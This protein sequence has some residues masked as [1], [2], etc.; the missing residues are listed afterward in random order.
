MLVNIPAGVLA[1]RPRSARR[2]LFAELAVTLS[3]TDVA[4]EIQKL[5]DQARLVGARADAGCARR[6]LAAAGELPAHA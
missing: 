2:V 5:K 4:D 3:A 1:G 6:S